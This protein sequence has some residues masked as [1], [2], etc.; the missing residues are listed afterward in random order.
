VTSYNLV[1][2]F[3]IVG[4]VKTSGLGMIITGSVIVFMGFLGQWFFVL[5]CSERLT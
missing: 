1:S 4:L 2:G 3:N 5:N